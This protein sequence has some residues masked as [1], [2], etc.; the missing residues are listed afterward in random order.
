MA[1]RVGEIPPYLG[2]LI[3]VDLD[4]NAALARTDPAITALGNNRLICHVRPRQPGRRVA[5]ATIKSFLLLFFKKEVLPY[6]SLRGAPD[7]IYRARLRWKLV[8]FCSWCG[9]G[10]VPR[11]PRDFMPFCTAPMLEKS[12]ASTRPHFSAFASA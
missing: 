4:N 3:V 7:P 2:D 6:T 1:E 11:K 9:L 8:I 10:S 5:S 12:W